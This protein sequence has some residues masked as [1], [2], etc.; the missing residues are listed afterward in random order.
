MTTQSRFGSRNVNY[1]KHFSSSIS[2]EDQESL[3]AAQQMF[4]IIKSRSPKS[5]FDEA[6]TIIKSLPPNPKENSFKLPLNL[7]SNALYVNDEYV[8]A[9]KLR[10]SLIKYNLRDLYGYVSY[11]QDLSKLCNVT[12]HPSYYFLL[13]CA[14][15][16]YKQEY[17]N[18][19][20][21]FDKAIEYKD[22]CSPELLASIYYN[23]G[24]C[25]LQIGDTDYSQEC[26]ELCS[27]LNPNKYKHTILPVKKIK[28]RS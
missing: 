9:L 8:P 28:E 13:A 12:H 11:M 27:L 16:D 10:C 5:Y 21:I 6:L 7:L 26:F 1:Y 25:F 2:P 17:N 20:S 24:F 18:A 19:I 23:Q 4:K 3:H 22:K 14:Y 15:I